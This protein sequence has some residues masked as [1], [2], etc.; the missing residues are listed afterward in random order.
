MYINM[1][2]ELFYITLTVFI[3]AIGT[4]IYL[5]YKNKKEINKLTEYSIN[6]SASIDETIPQLI[7]AIVSECFNEYIVMNIEY[8]QIQYINAE[9]ETK[10]LKEVGALVAKRMSPAMLSKLS[11]YYNLKHIS[12]IIS[13]K[14]YIIVLNYV[15]EHN[16][17]KDDKSELPG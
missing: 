4:F 13:D 7:E 5:W 15:L 3:I 8:Q 16:S 10:I 17:T 6:I 14:L 1:I 2:R 9:L 12:E 11:L